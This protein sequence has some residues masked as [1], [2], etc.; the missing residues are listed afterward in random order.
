GAS[1]LILGPL[2][3]VNNVLDTLAASFAYTWMSNL[4]FSNH[5]TIDTTTVG[6]SMVQFI[7]W[8]CNFNDGWKWH[9]DGNS[10]VN[11]ILCKS[12]LFYGTNECSGFQ[13]FWTGACQFLGGSVLITGGPGNNAR[14]SWLSQNTSIGSQFAPTNVTLRWVAPQPVGQHTQGDWVA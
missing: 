4:V 9:S 11:N 13:F 12:C 8:N 14:A 6:N 2:V 7:C 10:G 5:Q 1:G 3:L